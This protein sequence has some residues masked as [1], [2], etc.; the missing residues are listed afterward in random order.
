VREVLAAKLIHNPLLLHDAAVAPAKDAAS[1]SLPV[2][3]VS[4]F[5]TAEDLVQIVKA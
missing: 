3:S 5:L 4:D 1:V 2:L